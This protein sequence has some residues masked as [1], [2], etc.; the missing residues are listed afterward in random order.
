MDI[1]KTIKLLASE[2]KIPMMEMFA[3]AISSPSLR[4]GKLLQ[5]QQNLL[6]SEAAQHIVFFDFETNGLK[7]C[8]VLSATALCV[9]FCE[10][11]F[12]IDSLFNRFYFPREGYNE[13][14]IAI[15]KLSES[16]IEELR[17]DASYPRYFDEDEEWEQLCCWGNLF[18]AH[19]IAFDRRFMR[20]EPGQT[21]CT[22]LA[23][24]PILQL[25]R[26]YWSGEWKWPK[27]QKTAEYYQIPIQKS[28]LH[29]G[30]YDAWLC[31]IVFRE[32]Y[33][34]KNVD[35]FQFLQIGNSGKTQRRKV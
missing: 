17:S 34:R 33:R 24:A 23:N 32:M 18:V 13:E 21:F 29:Y 26:H 25:G 9:N 10:G 19:N 4:Q 6:K 16:R 22:M 20:H 7:D 8:S 14:A 1:A 35:V 27:L 2:Y 31:F 11:K 5:A 28:L 3:Y 12:I 30:F 15:N